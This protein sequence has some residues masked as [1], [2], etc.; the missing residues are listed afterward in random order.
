M[1]FLLHIRGI[2]IESSH[3]EDSGICQAKNLT[4]LKAI[5]ALFSLTLLLTACEFGSQPQTDRHLVDNPAGRGAR[6]PRLSAF[7]GG[8]VLMSWVEPHADG[9]ILKFAVHQKDGWVREGEVAQGS[10]WFINWADFPSVVALDESFWAAHWLVKHPNGRPYD[11]DIALSISTD[12]GSTWS[13]TQAP[14]RDGSAAEHGFVTMYP[15]DDGAGLL[16]LDGR[17]HVAKTEPHV[18]SKPSGNFTLRHARIGRDGTM[19]AEHILDSNTCTCCW[20][21]VAMTSLGPIASWRSRTDHDIRDHAISRWRE[22]HWSAPMPLGQEAWHIAGCPTNGPALAARGLHVAAAW[23]TAAEDRPRIRAAISLDGGQHFEPPVEID[24]NDP[25]GRTGVAWL[26]E[27]TAVISWMTTPQD[28]TGRA[29]LALRTFSL[30]HTLGPVQKITDMSGGRDSGVPQLIKGESGL[31]LAWT[32]AAPDYG[33][34]TMWMNA[35]EYNH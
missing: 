30:D 32:A 26:D 27:R 6:L 21:S 29:T 33:I 23:F 15:V 24:E 18:D 34:Q 35:M 4:P 16:W 10:D 2:P 12:A 9:Y 13:P 5:L 7:P 3:Q 1:A 19:G 8:G 17:D 22:N 25:I 28:D 11:Y 20:T 14:H 31:L